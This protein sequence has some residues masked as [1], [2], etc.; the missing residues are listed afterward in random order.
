MQWLVTF[1]N[2]LWWSSVREG[3]CVVR[4]RCYG[5]NRKAARSAVEEANEGIAKA[6]SAKKEGE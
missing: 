4:M 5:K 1:Y 3:G 2:G 6:R